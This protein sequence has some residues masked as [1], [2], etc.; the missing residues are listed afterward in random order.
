MK[1]QSLLAIAG[2]LTL[3]FS[4]GDAGGYSAGISGRSM[5]GCGGAGCHGTA[6]N[7][8]TS[9]APATS[10]SGTGANVTVTISSPVATTG[11]NQ[12]GFNL[13]ATFGTL[14]KTP[15]TDPTVQVFSGSEVGHT[16]GG[17]DQ[18]SWTV[19]WEPPA[20]KLCQYGFLVA[21]NAVDGDGVPSTL[22]H[23]NLGSTSITVS[24]S[25]DTTP[26]A[27]PGVVAPAAGNT[28]VNNTPIP[29]PGV[30]V[31]IGSITLQATAGDQTGIDHVEFLDADQFG[32]APVGNATYNQNTNRFTRIWNTFTEPPGP[33]TLTVRAIDC[34]GNQSD[35]TVELFIL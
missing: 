13:R 22:D 15:A 11:I 2:A 33:H 28:Y 6:A 32:T 34:A 31:V 25:G 7:G 16:S 17:N 21:G 19:H 10:P 5:S 24:G 26:P 20:T 29:T 3:A 8:D 14:S 4:P 35:T 18:R 12:G 1:T 27:T 23:W 9:V 30:I